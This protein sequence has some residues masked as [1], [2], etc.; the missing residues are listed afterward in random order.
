MAAHD[1]SKTSWTDLA[2]ISCCSGGSRVTPY[3]PN[4]LSILFESIRLVPSGAV[5]YLFCL[6]INSD[7]VRT[8]GVWSL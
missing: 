4:V 7:G 2:L 3:P 8:R 6:N 1:R 5:I